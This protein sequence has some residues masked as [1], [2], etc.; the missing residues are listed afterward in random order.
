MSVFPY[1]P[2]WYSIITCI[3]ASALIL[4]DIKYWAV[5]FVDDQK[6]Q[7]ALV[8][9]KLLVR[10]WPLEPVFMGMNFGFQ[11]LLVLWPK[12]SYFIILFI[13]FSCR[14]WENYLIGFLWEL[15]S[16]KAVLGQYLAQSKPSMS[17]CYC[18]DHFQYY[19]HFWLLYRWLI[20]K[21]NQSEI[22][23]LE[24]KVDF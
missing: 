23:D 20:E 14:N 22:E 12:I 1:S 24:F 15:N 9:V 8:T 21:Y 4:F 7:N 6:G 5:S 3:E 17:F 18:N 16:Y 19:H 10:M 11:H 13:I 2:T